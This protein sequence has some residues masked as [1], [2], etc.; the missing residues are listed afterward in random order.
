V[1]RVQYSLFLQVIEI[2]TGLIEFQNEVTRS[3][4]IKK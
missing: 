3:K 1:R 4:Q 2:E